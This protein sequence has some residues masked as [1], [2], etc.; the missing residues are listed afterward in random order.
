MS[1]IILF[2]FSMESSQSDAR[3]QERIEELLPDVDCF[4]VYPN[5]NYR[6]TRGDVIVGWG[7]G[8][9]PDW[10]GRVPAGVAYLNPPTAVM[11]CVNKTASFRAF[12]AAG[13]RCVPF[14]TSRTEAAAWAQEGH[15]VMA[16]NLTEGRDGEGAQVLNT[17]EEVRDSGAG[18][19]TL[20]I[21]KAAEYR[22]HVFNGNII[23][24]QQRTRRDGAT[25]TNHHIRTSSN[26]WGLTRSWDVSVSAELR[27][28]AVSAVAA[29]GLQFGAV[30]VGV[31]RFGRDFVFEVNSAPEVL[32]EG[33][34]RYANAIVAQHAA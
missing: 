13:V 23:G 11:K 5:R 28:N 27:N 16:R 24:V 30:D 17:I 29:L 33:V 22:V 9:R 2:P 31:D 21:P 6:P 34:N 26:G 12:A 10:H 1:R 7:A 8:D 14:T 19:F 4:R 20:F 25:I 18:L 32:G 3:I 15:R